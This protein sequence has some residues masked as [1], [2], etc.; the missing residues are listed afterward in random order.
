[1]TLPVSGAI[2]FNDI[3]VELG[4]AGTTQASLGQA[5]FR[6]L[7]GVASGAISMSDFYGKANQ[8]NLTISSNQTNVNL[9][10]FATSAGWNGTSKLVATINSGVYVSSS[11]TGT[12]ALTISGSFP[13]GLEVTNDGFIV[14]MGG[15]GGSGTRTNGASGSSGGTALSVSSAV[16]FTNNGTI[17][18]GGGGGGAGTGA[19]WS[20]SPGCSGDFLGSVS[21]GGGGGG[22]SS[23]TNA[24]GGGAE[25]GLSGEYA[26][27]DAGGGGT[28]TAASAGGGGSNAQ[29]LTGGGFGVQSGVGGSGGDWGVSGS[30]GGSGSKVGGAGGHLTTYTI[31]SGG[32]SGAAVSGNSNITY[33]ATGT[34][35]GAI[36]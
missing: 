32:A 9:A 24:G 33:L 20:R 30:G 26:A 10:T 7:A 19:C 21:G 6:T 29:V 23:Q 4:V 28:G 11:S 13:G 25:P 3:N 35:L 5:S 22:R 36:T 16:L 27:G 1:M 17:A 8:F 12:P 15:G 34:R 2:S 14:G 18:G 31:G